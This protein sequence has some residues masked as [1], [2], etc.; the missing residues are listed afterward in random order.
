MKLGNA[1]PRQPFIG[2]AGAAILGV[3]CADIAPHHQLGIALLVASAAFALVRKSTRV[4]Y[5]SVAAAF[6]VLHSTRETESPGVRLA[7]QLGGARHAVTARGVVVSE[8]RISARGMSSFH[9]RLSSLV[10]EGQTSSSHATLLARWRGEVRYGD[11]LQLFGVAQPLE[12]PRNPGEFDMRAYLARRDV[13]YSLVV[14]Y[15]ENGQVLARDRGSWIMRAAQHSRAAMHAALGRGLEDSPDLH[16]LI[17]GMVLGTRDE[18]PDEIEEQ[19]QQTGTLHLFAVSGLN[20]AIVAHLLWMVL[21]AARVPRKWAIALIIPGLFFYAAITGLNASSVRAALMAAVLLGGFLVE[22]KVLTGNSIAAAA[23][24]VLCWDTNQLFSTGFQLSFAVV[25]AIIAIAEPLFRVFMRW[26]EPDP[27]LPKS[28]LNRAQRSGLSVWHAIARGASVS[29]AAWLGSLP[30]ILP[31]FYLITPV[32]LFANL[33]VVP[34]AFFVL[35]IGLM[36]LLVSP[37]ATWLAVIFNN[38]NWS[39]AAAILGAVGIFARAPA[40]HIY[41]GAPHWP[42]GARVDVTALD[43]GAGGCVHVR[44]RSRDWLVDSGSER[45]FKR[46]VRSYLRSRGINH[47]DGLLLTHGDAAHIGGAE[48]MLRAFRPRE[49]VDTAAP[50]RSPVH[51][52]LIAQFQER[53]IKPR[54]AAAATEVRLGPDVTARLLFP[55]ANFRAKTADDQAVVLQLAVAKKWRLLLM[56]DSGEGSEKLLLASG[57]DVRSD[58]LIKGQHHSGRSGSP[59]FLDA[60]QPQLIVASSR[61]FPESERIKDE[62]AESVTAR[63]IRLF[64]QDET[65]AVT[66]RFYGKHW[67]AIPYLARDQIFR[68]ASR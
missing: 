44:N 27:F 33:V 39:L 51:R 58:I 21:S 28:L 2:I 35:A 8:P 12:G 10:R 41:L 15:P 34:L 53:E 37:A 47:L 67:E 13:R 29:L 16:A 23:V 19:F 4:T 57:A 14:R 42:T 24:L 49:I 20:V 55:P 9:F 68:S 66:V 63:G 59:E 52:R 60:V 38:A 17:S 61:A 18:T 25:I 54:L 46:V 50:D 64:R 36:S 65:G 30:L 7:R 43:L 45:D 40:G 11:E 26:F 5:L 31:Y 32:S 48:A 3:V 62:W 1:W 6:F 56:S 22:R